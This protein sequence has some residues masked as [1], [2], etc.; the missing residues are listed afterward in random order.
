M[1]AQLSLSN[2][3]H[4]PQVMM[5]T[6]GMDFDTLLSICKAAVDN[7]CNAFDTAP[8]YVSEQYLGDVIKRLGSEYGI[9]RDQLF[10]QTKL[11]WKDQMNKCVEGAFYNSL[12]RL[13]LEYID[14]YLMHWPYPDTFV[15]DWKILEKLYKSGVVKSIGTC[16]FLQ[17]HWD[18]LL[19]SNIEILP[20]INQIELH[21]LRTCDDLLAFCKKHNILTQAYTPICKMLPPIKDNKVLN[22]LSEKYQT[23]VPKLILAWHVSRGVVP[24]TKST[25]PRRVKDNLSCVE[26][27]ISSKDLT[28]ITSLNED[29][30]FMVESWGCPGF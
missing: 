2:G 27:N 21:P 7:A 12:N 8:N 23:S 18:K 11:D 13:G 6:N 4:L 3:C 1:V 25:K 10:I 14:S 26:L 17:R 19:A 29:Y 9:N 28:L 5:G 22:D 16:N 24:I 15:S 30:K 20:H